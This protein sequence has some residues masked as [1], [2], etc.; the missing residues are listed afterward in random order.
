[1]NFKKSL[2]FLLTLILIMSTPGLAQEVQEDTEPEDSIAAVVNGEEI[3]VKEVDEHANLQQLLMSLY[4]SNQEFAQLLMNSEVGNNLIDEYRK[5]KV[6]EMVTRE[7]LL[8]EAEE[9]GIEISSEE[10]EE[11]LQEQINNIQQQQDINEEEMQEML[12]QQGIESM[13]EFK[14]MLF[15]NNREALILNKLQEEVVGDITVSEEEVKLYYEDNQDEYE[16]DEQVQA[17]HILVETEEE[18][19]EVLD[20]LNNGESFGDLVENYSTDTGTVD[21]GG[22]LGFLSKGQMVPEFEEVAFSL[23][24]GEVS[25]PVESQ[26]GY[27]IIKVTDKKEA[28]VT[29]LE[30]VKDEI[31]E[32]IL[33]DRR[34]ED[35][36][37]F[38]DSLR[39]EAEIEIKL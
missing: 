21:E 33:N 24:I 20:K 1:M 38:R 5:L 39:E 36:S 27:H 25:E 4:Q 15:E 3:M 32:R 34:N 12:N 13:D 35:W 14:E 18:A 29:P 28:G 26:Y 7:V 30:D 23:E 31:E 17:S 16:H 37:D 6:E 8:Q 9:R 10:K 22:D 2:L 11:I 19:G